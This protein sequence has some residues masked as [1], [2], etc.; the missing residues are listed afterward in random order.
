[1]ACTFHVNSLYEVLTKNLY[2]QER[3][4][5]DKTL[6]NLED[7]PRCIIC[8]LKVVKIRLFEWSE[9]NLQ[10]PKYV[11]ENAQVLD[12]LTISLVIPKAKAGVNKV[13]KGELLSA[14]KSIMLYKDKGWE[15]KL[16]EA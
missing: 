7:V 12:R 13:I 6:I 10:F 4:Q 14:P 11:L 1:M 5:F 3:S 16:E 8:S 2:I 15:N 9:G